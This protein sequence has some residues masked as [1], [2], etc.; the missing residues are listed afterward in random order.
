MLYR[1]RKEGGEE[2]SL[3]TAFKLSFIIPRNSAQVPKV[4]TH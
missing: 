2:G 4:Q 1:I 3:F